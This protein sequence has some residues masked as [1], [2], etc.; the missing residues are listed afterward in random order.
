MKFAKYLQAESVPEWRKKYINY[1][2]LKKLLKEIAKVHA[3]RTRSEQAPVP[4]E[5]HS[6][7]ADASIKVPEVKIREASPPRYNLSVGAD[8]ATI[9]PG[10]SSLRPNLTLIQVTFPSYF[11]N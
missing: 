5:R 11:N 3:E 1:K 10:Q 9:Q 8:A 6:G 4:I 7:G 2:L